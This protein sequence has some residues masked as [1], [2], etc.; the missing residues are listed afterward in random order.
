VKEALFSI[1]GGLC[2]SFEGF[3]VLDMFAGTGGLGIEALSRGA[4]QAVF[5]DSSREAVRLIKQNL[6]ALGL[7]ASGRV[8][9]KEALAALKALETGGERFHLVFLDPPYARGLTEKVLGHLATSAL[10]DAATVI[11]AETA[12]R[13]ALP[14]AFD[15]LRLFDRRVYGDTALS[16]LRLEDKG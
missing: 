4:A 15:R 8:L 16:F 7:A 12:A 6:D 14:E 2:G 11:V 9:P 1:L 10:I 3:K 13:D 5:V